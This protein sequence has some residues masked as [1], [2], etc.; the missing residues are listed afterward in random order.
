M[1]TQ[2]ALLIGV[3]Y[4]FPGRQR[5][6]RYDHLR[7]CVND[8]SRIEAFLKN[9][10]AQNIYKLV[11]PCDDDKKL[12]DMKQSDLPTYQNVK[13]KI[14]HITDSVC[15]GDS[16]WIHYSGHGILRHHVDDYDSD[17]GDEINGTAFALTDVQVGG[18]YLTGYQLGVWVR[19]LVE[20]KKT[21]VTVTLD[22]CYS[23]KGFRNSNKVTMRTS[24]SNTIDNSQ[25]DSDFEADDD[26]VAEDVR[27]GHNVQSSTRNAIV[28][29]SW[30]SNPEGCT[31]LTACRLDQEAGECHLGDPGTSNGIMTHFLLDF[32]DKCRKQGSQLPTYQRLAQQ[33]KH[34]VLAMEMS[35]N[36]QTPVLQGDSLLEFLGT[37]K[38]IQHSGCFVQVLDQPGTHDKAYL[39][40]VGSTQGVCPGA[41]YSVHPDATGDLEPIARICIEEVSALRSK[42]RLIKLKEPS[43]HPVIKSGN[44]AVLYSWSLPTQQVVRFNGLACLGDAALESALSRLRNQVQSMPHFVLCPEGSNNEDLDHSITFDAVKKGFLVEARQNK[45]M[46]QLPTIASNDENVIPKVL[47]LLKH[48]ARFHALKYFNHGT[49]SKRFQPDDYSFELLEYQGGALNSSE[50]IYQAKEDQEVTVR[51]TNNSAVDNVHVA[52][53]L[54]NATYG[55]ERLCPSE[56][57]P[58]EQ[59]PRGKER[60]M[61]CDLGLYIPD[62]ESLEAR[63]V[64]RAYVYVG[65]NPPSW[66]ELILPDIPANASQVPTDLLVEAIPETDLKGGDVT[67]NGKKIKKKRAFDENASEWGILE[68]TVRTT[69]V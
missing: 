13:G 1:P 6:V 52:I 15:P 23:G 44:R 67:R 39:L 11:A 35:R 55:T 18:A 61:T 57:Q 32:I 26:A 65:D 16:V 58:T 29:K 12:K 60:P 63:D 27:M 53:F 2:W 41:E 7:G 21:R 69:R 48:L 46:R 22:S 51:F 24:Q 28:R 38:R 34:K 25:L 37:Q 17:D 14:Q 30:L 68:F 54:F 66:D 20:V 5:N 56:G 43:E 8:V 36:P 47:Y 64:Y 31:V 49:H 45:G 10:G 40:D 42:A 9:I 62:S 50:G 59:V 4:Y 33:I 3:D 19:K